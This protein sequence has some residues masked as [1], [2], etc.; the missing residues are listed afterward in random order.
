MRPFS[1]GLIRLPLGASEELHART[2]DLNPPA[3]PYVGYQTWGE[4]YRAAARCIGAR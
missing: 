2:L 1:T 4:S 3:A